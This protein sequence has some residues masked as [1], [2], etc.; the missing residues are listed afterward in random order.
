M[1]LE[2]DPFTALVKVFKDATVALAAPL[3][4]NNAGGIEDSARH[5]PTPAKIL[6]RALGFCKD[7]DYALNSPTIYP[8][9]VGGMFMLFPSPIFKEFQ[10]FDERFFLYYED[11]DLCARL[12]LSGKKIVLCSNVSV[13]HQA[14]RNSHRQFNYFCWHVSSM[15]RFFFSSVYR[16]IRSHQRQATAIQ[17]PHNSKPGP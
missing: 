3:V 13:V 12:K 1:R 15:V 6:C 4:K 11:V 9:W 8:D 16:K 10:G 14:Q 17:L 2:Q 5:F 7:R